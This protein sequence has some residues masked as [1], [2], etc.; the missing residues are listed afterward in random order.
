MISKYTGHSLV[1]GV[2]CIGLIF[3]LSVR[4]LADGL[5]DVISGVA[6]NKPRC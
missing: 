3:A 2:Q 5:N 1:S 6:G 4:G